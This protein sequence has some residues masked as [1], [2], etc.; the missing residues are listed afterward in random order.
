MSTSSRSVT[1]E[2][3]VAVPP[4]VAF[5]AFTDELDLWWVR[6]PINHWA[7]GRL[8]EMRCEPG[9]GGRLLEI[10]DG[11]ECLELARITVW[12]PGR[13]LAWSSSV[14]DV[15]TE[16]RFEAHVAGTTVRV[17]A[18]IPEGGENRGGTSWTRVV[19]KWF[20]AWCTRREGASRHVADIARLALGISYTKPATAARWLADVFGFESPD[21]LP[22]G[23]DPLPETEHGHPWIEFRIGNSS[24]MIFKSDPSTKAGRDSRTH[25]PWVYVADIESH[26]Q[27]A[28]ERGAAIVDKLSS[29]WGLPLYTADDLEGHHWTFAQARPTM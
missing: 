4:D 21:P 16:I 10:Y 17:I 23:D 26:Y 24:L 29:P 19:P 11:D 28:L 2:V 13:R 15:E 5:V 1:S 18:R 20:G 6:G 14:D 3:N 7:A 27:R 8:R 12:E 25:V 9:I 22:E